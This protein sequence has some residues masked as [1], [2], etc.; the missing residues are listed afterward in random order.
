M[1]GIMAR[2]QTIKVSHTQ[3]LGEAVLDFGL[4]PTSGYQKVGLSPTSGY[5]DVGLQDT[6]GYQTWGFSDSIDGSDVTNL[7]ND[8]TSGF[9]EFG[10]VNIDD[11]IQ[12]GLT[13]GVQ[14]S[15]KLSVDGGV[16]NE[17]SIIPAP[18]TSEQTILTFANEDTGNY[19][20]H[21]FTLYNGNDKYGVW[22]NVDTSGSQPTI[23]DVID[24]IE[25]AISSADTGNTIATA[26]SNALEDYTTN[27]LSGE[28]WSCSIDSNILTLSL[29]HI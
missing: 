28:G 29:I 19:T 16:E 4:T 15:F 20:N 10:L 5:Q 22:F 21:Y 24:Y 14:Y 12:S 8:P 3:N 25:V 9:Q 13:A 7:L 26:V 6:I 11:S 17:Y 27:N 18:A 2:E 23:T 1:V